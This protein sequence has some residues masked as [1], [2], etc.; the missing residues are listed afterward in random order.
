M[1]G[2]N[3]KKP[4]K[5]P[6]KPLTSEA[7]NALRLTGNHERREKRANLQ[8]NI[9]RWIKYGTLAAVPLLF[10]VLC[11]I[12]WVEGNKPGGNQEE[13]TRYLWSAITGLVG[14]TIGKVVKNNGDDD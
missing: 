9:E 8:L 1:F 14:Y 5:Y 7:V 4:N 11:Y 2:R 13:L 6:G 12:S 3:K 10:V